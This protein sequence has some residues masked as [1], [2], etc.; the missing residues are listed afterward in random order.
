M[1]IKMN[2]PQISVPSNFITGMRIGNQVLTQSKEEIIS[3]LSQE[4]QNEKKVQYGPLLSSINSAIYTLSGQSKRDS[5]RNSY[6]A[7][8]FFEKQVIQLLKKEAKP[9]PTSLI[10]VVS[11]QST[12]TTEF[13][14]KSNMRTAVSTSGASHIYSGL[15]NN[16]TKIKRG[17]SRLEASALL[18]EHFQKFYNT[19]QNHPVYKKYQ[20]N[21]KSLSQ[22][23]G[24]I[25]EAF[26]SHVALQHT[27]LLSRSANMINV[28]NV[29]PN[30]F[31]K[32]E[33]D[34]IVQMSTNRDRWTT[35]GD[36]ILIDKE[37]QILL[38]IQVKA[39]LM[40]A[41]VVG[42]LSRTELLKDLKKLK[43]MVLL[44]QNNGDFRPMLEKLYSMFEVSAI[45]EKTDTRIEQI[46][47]QTVKQGII[48]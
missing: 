22:I 13:I 43:E 17:Y 1:K 31:S 41:S 28:Q 2:K 19:V 20:K 7:Y 39:T 10:T 8:E 21:S 23:H 3:S 6:K 18:S 44:A 36:V 40:K 25:A 38:N 15:K 27:E 45:I 29:L 5:A 35:G 24:F 37:G 48:I 46:T 9:I 4:F 33:V 26:I 34:E 12:G 30:D 16:G 47:N 14:Q 11:D 32:K 42:N